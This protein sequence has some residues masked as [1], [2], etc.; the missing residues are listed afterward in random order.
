MVR[1]DISSL[2]GFSPVFEVHRIKKTMV[3]ETRAID[4]Q[5]NVFL[6]TKYIAEPHKS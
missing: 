4:K 5:T 3:L 1:F 2:L 6:P